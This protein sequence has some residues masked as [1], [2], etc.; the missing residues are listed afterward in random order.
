MVREQAEFTPK[1]KYLLKNDDLVKGNYIRIINN[2]MFQVLLQN[3]ME[4]ILA[5]FFHCVRNSF[6]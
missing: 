3:G 1:I 2:Y 6:Q 4:V 5:A